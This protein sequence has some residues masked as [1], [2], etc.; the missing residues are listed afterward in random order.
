MVRMSWDE[1]GE[2]LK[3][4]WNWDRSTL[5]LHLN[6]NGFEDDS[7][8]A[9]GITRKNTYFVMGPC[10]WAGAAFDSYAFDTLDVI[11]EDFE[12][13]EVDFE[14]IMQYIKDFVADHTI[15]TEDEIEFLKL[16]FWVDEGWL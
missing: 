5:V 16:G 3:D 6:P 14:M 1:L 13:L 12:D 8:V 4:P 9:Y 10:C 11:V 15:S 2:K 7:T